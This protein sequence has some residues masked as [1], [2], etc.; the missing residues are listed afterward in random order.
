MQCNDMQCSTWHGI[1]CMLCNTMYVMQ[2]NVCQAMQGWHTMHCMICNAWRIVQC[3]ES[4][5]IYRL[6]YIED[7]AVQYMACS[8]C[9]IVQYNTKMTYSTKMTCST[10]NA[11]YV[12]QYM[13]CGTKMTCNAKITCNTINAIHVIQCTAYSA[14]H[15][16]RYV[17]EELFSKMH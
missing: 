8:V 5:R 11:M 2:G 13:T 3:R 16:R 7:H 14:I 17:S 6:N 12:V 10:V 1:Q 9:H 15:D 4:K